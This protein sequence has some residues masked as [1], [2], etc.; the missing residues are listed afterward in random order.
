MFKDDMPAQNAQ[1]GCKQRNDAV[2][3]LIK[4]LSVRGEHLGTLATKRSTKFS[5]L[6]RYDEAETTQCLCNHCGGTW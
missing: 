6:G 4:E 5:I 3:V 1:L 2:W